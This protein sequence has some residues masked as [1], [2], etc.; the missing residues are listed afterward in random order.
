MTSPYC[1]PA[2]LL[3]PSA[4]AR[5]P[6]NEDNIPR[7]FSSSPPAPSHLRASSLSAQQLTAVPEVQRHMPGCETRRDPG[8][9]L[10]RGAVSLP[11]R[12]KPPPA[13]TNHRVH[14]FGASPCLALALSLS[15]SI[16][17]YPG[18]SVLLCLSTYDD[19]ILRLARNITSNTSHV[20]YRE[21]RLLPS[22]RRY[23]VPTH[24][25]VR[26]KNHQSTI[27]LKQELSHR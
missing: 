12:Q 16:S 26:L 1:H 18:F 6:D 15:I 19:S 25:E 23:S 7:H 21:Y 5:R 27:R 2:Q 11:P 4:S 24:N 10:Y 8:P 14:C 3:L 20:L 22:G 9:P 13:S 17:M